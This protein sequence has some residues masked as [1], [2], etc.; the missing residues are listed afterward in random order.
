MSFCTSSVTLCMRYLTFFTPNK[1]SVNTF[2]T[3]ELL[4]LKAA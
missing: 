1:C 2:Y 4:V 3:F